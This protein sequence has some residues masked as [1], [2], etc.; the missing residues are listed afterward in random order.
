VGDVHEARIWRD[1]D[2]HAFQI[3]TT[4]LAVPKSVIKTMVGREAVE[5]AM[6][7]SALGLA[8]PNKSIPRTKNP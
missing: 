5:P 7:E 3:A 4:S 8:Q 6:C 1:A 2:H